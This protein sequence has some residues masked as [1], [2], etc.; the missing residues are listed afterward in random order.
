M[1]VLRFWQTPPRLEPSRQAHA[2][3]GSPEK[4]AR[5]L[6][7]LTRANRAF[8]GIR[9]QL[10]PLRR[11]LDVPRGGT[12]RLLDVGCGGGDIPRA[13]V[14]WARRRRVPIQVVVVDKDPEAIRRASA[15]LRPYPEVRLVRADAFHLPFPPRS[16]DFV[17]SAM[18]LHYFSPEDAAAVLSL[19]ATLASRAVLINDIERHWFPCAAIKVLRRFSG[20]SLFS[21]ASLQ[22]VLRGFTPE[23]MDGLGRR[24]GLIRPEV[25]RFFPFR[26][27]L[28]AL[29]PPLSDDGS[30]ARGTPP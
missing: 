17:T 21:E 2:F 24:A 4:V 7:D 13:F 5:A 15:R 28:V 27:T 12:I 29:V 3:G 1:C 26:L 10:A 22:T 6:A 23:E 16:F 18:L 9:S 30:L 20:S 19:W 14:G 8:G 25:R 11:L